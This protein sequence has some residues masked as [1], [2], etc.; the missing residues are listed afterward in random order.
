M[1]IS[2]FTRPCSM[3]IAM[4]TTQPMS[5][6]TQQES[7]PMSMNIPLRNMVT[8]TCP[9]FITDMGMSDSIEKCYG[10]HNKNEINSKT[11][12]S[13]KDDHRDDFSNACWR[14][15]G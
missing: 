11:Y 6:T 15:N 7:T 13:I 12:F 10:E 2:T 4:V 14:S 8:T 9:I 5:M 1:N 3:T